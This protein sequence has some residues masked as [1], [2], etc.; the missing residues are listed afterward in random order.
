LANEA[1]WVWLE[2]LWLAPYVACIRRPKTV[3]LD[4]HNVESDFYRQLRQA[5]RHPV[6]RVGY[7]VFEQA[8]RRVERRYLPCFDRIVAVSDED[9]RLLERDC[10]P[11]KIFV[12]PNAF[13]LHPLPVADNLAR[14]NLYFAG[15]LDYA[16]N[17][18]G[19]LWFYRR[20]WALIR[21]RLPE[22]RWYIVG[23]C[24][25]V[26]RA[27]LGD[28]SHIILVGEVENTDPY[29]ALS[30]LVI[31]PLPIGGGTRFKILE[32]WSAGK[33]VVSTTKGAQ[34]LAARHGENIWI[35]D[36]AVEFADAVVRLLPDSSLRASLGRRGRETVEEQYSWECLQERLEAAL[37]QS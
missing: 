33:A 26:L 11:E 15:R 23:A 34:G 13:K 18:E 5:S 12:L 36:T 30:S 9:R 29:L 24:P 35:A 14:K 31:V 16:A 20:V 21:N 19:V 22:V 25:E 2:H 4:V 32:G 6:D 37:F 8:A 3:V 27:E 17:R 1:D 7:Y 10:S 28:D